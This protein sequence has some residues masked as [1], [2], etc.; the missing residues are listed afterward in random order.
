MK[1]LSTILVLMALSLTSGCSI[2]GGTHNE[3]TIVEP[4]MPIQAVGNKKGKSEK[5]VVTGQE[6]KSG[7]IATQ[8]V[9][10]WVMMP[11]SHW[12]VVANILEQAKKKGIVP[13]TTSEQVPAEVVPLPEKP[14]P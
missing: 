14:A 7:K 8:D 11:P 9:N 12:R 2:L 4:G 10:G 3:Y 5:N 13:Q 6:L 1:R